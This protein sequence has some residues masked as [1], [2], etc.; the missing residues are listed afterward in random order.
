MQ[1][2]IAN[3]KEN[4]LALFSELRQENQIDGNS[5]IELQMDNLVDE[6]KRTARQR[7]HNALAECRTQIVQQ[8]KENKPITDKVR[9][10]AIQSIDPVRYQITEDE[11]RRAQYEELSGAGVLERFDAS[12][13]TANLL[14]CMRSLSTMSYIWQWK[15]IVRAKR[16]F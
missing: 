1:Q 9:K 7:I 4:V 3:L 6:L 5:S 8:C 14:Q 13:W 12:I 11:I 15:S 2:R 10:N 16:R